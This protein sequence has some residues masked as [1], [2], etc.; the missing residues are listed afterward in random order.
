V[1]IKVLKEKSGH[2]EEI[3][4]TNLFKKKKKKRNST[5]HVFHKFSLIFHYSYPWNAMFFLAGN[6]NSLSNYFYRHEFE[7]KTKDD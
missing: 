6:S 4:R 3:F 1:Q 7:K 2:I 5:L